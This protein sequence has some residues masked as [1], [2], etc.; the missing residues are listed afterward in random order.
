VAPDSTT[1]RFR[2]ATSALSMDIV[3]RA[4]QPLT[5]AKQ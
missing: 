1:L 2:W 3:T 4:T 5:G